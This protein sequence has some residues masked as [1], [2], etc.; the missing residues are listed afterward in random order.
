MMSHRILC[1]IDFSVA[2]EQ[3]MRVAAR[4]SAEWQQEL[5]VAYACY[6]PRSA[7]TGTARLPEEM[8][9]RLVDE[10]ELALVDAAQT[11]GELGPCSVSSALFSGS[12]AEEIVEALNEDPLFDL[13]VM[14]THGRTGLRRAVMGSVT[15]HVI[16]HA[17]CS[18]L[19]MRRDT[20]L[21]DSG[22]R[23][24]L[25]A[26]D[27]SLSSRHALLYAE[28]VVERDIGRITPMHVQEAMVD[29]PLAVTVREIASA[30][31]RARTIDLVIVA[32]DST[33]RSRERLARIATNV[34]RRTSCPVLVARPR[35]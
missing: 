19:A 22:F 34:L 21:D 32:C 30:I 6:L 14:S 28:N 35:E 7:F 24:V 27:V 13:V 1:P 16:R 17:P 29:A 31:G 23:H 18:V 3:T 5:V 9:Q 25:C 15:E 12:P 20:V 8:M 26:L 4:L 10:D 33:S 2:S 11:A